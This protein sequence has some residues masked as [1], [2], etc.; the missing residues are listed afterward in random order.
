MSRHNSS[1]NNI[2]NKAQ[3]KAEQAASHPWVER[4]MRL[5]FAT[6]GVVYITIGLLAA[7]AAFGTGGQTTDSEGALKAISQQQFGVFLLSIIAVGLIGYA[8]W[9][10]V[11]AIIDPEH[12]KTDAKGIFQRLGYAMS[13]FIYSGLAFTAIKMLLG[14]GGSSGGGNS[15]QDWTARVLAQPFGEWLVGLAGAGV[16]GLGFYMLYEAYSAKFRRKLKLSEM[17]EDERKWTIRLGRVG[18]AA[19]GIVFCVIGLL[20]VQAARLSDAN[21]V[22][23]PDGALQ[24]LANQPFGPWVLGIVAIG[25]VAYGVFML[26]M[27]SSRRIAIG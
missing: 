5:G 7:Q 22:E 18:H 24:V 14:S 13:G 15:S 19:R 23:G 2:K 4:L 12:Q 25:L 17:S 8:L 21:Q 10:F 9:R 26:S 20:L 1:A 16:I 11:Q 3:D 6:K 27:A